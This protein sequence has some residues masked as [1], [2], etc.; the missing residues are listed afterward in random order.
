M[1]AGG[2][3]MQYRISNKNNCCNNDFGQTFAINGG[4]WI[5][6]SSKNP[7]WPK[8]LVVFS[9]FLPITTIVACSKEAMMNLLSIAIQFLKHGRQT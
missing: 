4:H 6:L 8:P 2:A 1:A 5:H 9:R 3:D 7:A